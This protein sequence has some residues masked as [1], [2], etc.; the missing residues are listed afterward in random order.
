MSEHEEEFDFHG[1]EADP[2]PEA[3]SAPGEFNELPPMLES[4]S[5]NGYGDW[6]S[7][8]LFPRERQPHMG[9]FAILSALIVVAILI[10]GLMTRVALGLHWLGVS[11]PE[12]AMND[13]RYTLGSMALIYVFTLSLATAFF[14]LVW[15][16]SLFAGVHWNSLGA[17]H[18]LKRL[19]GAACFCFVLAFL[20]GLLMPSPGD[21][22]IDHIFRTPGAPWA[23]F[24]FGISFAPFFEEMVFRGFLLPAL[25]TA[26]DWATEQSSGQR[27][28]LPFADGHP[29][30]SR[31][32]MIAAS[33][34]VSI[35]FALMHAEQTG[36]SVGP[37]VLLV[38]VSLV[39]CWARLST[40]SLAA[41][42]VVHASYNLL[43]FSLMFIGTGGFR[44]LEQM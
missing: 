24:G 3:N 26:L 20:S 37:M 35:P 7:R 30:W 9:H 2:Q 32:A 16:K 31:P 10:V 40:R 13:I 15:H 18:Q 11:T 25:C 36:Y 6:P 41:S 1:G 17:F 19:F 39:L 5:E 42:V 29:R 33:V 4:W 8:E 34:L 22:P 43:I 38:A 14:P 28:R 27:P 21:A 44:H 12:Q 23:L